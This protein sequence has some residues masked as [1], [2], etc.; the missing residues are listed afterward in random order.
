MTI[1]FPINQHTDVIDRAFGCGI[2]CINTTI[3][4]DCNELS[5]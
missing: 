2:D 3:N 4:V 5:D 1:L